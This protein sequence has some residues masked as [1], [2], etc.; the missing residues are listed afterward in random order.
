MRCYKKLLVGALLV[1]CTLHA[2]DNPALLQQGK[3]PIDYVDPF[4]GTSNSRWMQFPG[5]SMPFG[6]VQLSPD[7]QDQGWKGGYDYHINS[8]TGFSHIHSWTM[9]GLLVMPATGELQIEPGTEKQ[10]WKGY[11]SL[12]RKENEVSR[13][14]Y[15]SVFLDDYK[16]KAELTST[17]RVGVHRY[18]FP[19]NYRSRILF[20]LLIDA[21]YGYELN[22][23]FVT[24]V[25]DTEI[26]GFTFQQGHGG[27]SFNEYMVNFYIRFSKPFVTFNGWRKDEICRNIDGTFTSGWGHKDAGFFVEYDTEEGEQIQVQVGL[28]L[29]SPEQARLNLETEMKPFGWDFEAVVKNQENTWN[30]LLGKVEVESDNEINIKKFYTNMYR[31]YLARTIWSDV[32]GKYMDMY[33]KVQQ[34]KDP[35]SVVIGCDAFWNS[36]W[37][38]NGLWNLVTPAWSEKH[39]NSLLEI[40]DKGGWLPKGPAGIEYSGI[41]VGS[42]SIELIVS[43]YQAGIRNFDTMKA[44]EAMIH[45]QTV[46]G[47][48]HDAGGYAG[49]RNLDVYMKYGY[50]PNEFGPVTNTLDYA[51]DDWAVSEFA[52][53]LGD[54]EQGEYFAKRS[55]NFENVFDPSVK[56]VHMKNADGSWVEPFDS[57]CCSTFLGSGYVEGNAWQ[58]TWFV[59]HDVRYVV[60]FLGREEF[61]ARLNRGFKVSEPW[62]FSSESVDWS[63]SLESMGRLPINHGN[64]PNMQAAYL[65]NYAGRPWLTQ[66]WVRSIMERFYGDKPENGWMGDEDEGQM[67]AWYTLSSLGLFQMQG[68]CAQEPVWDIGSPQFKRA[69]IHLDDTY[70]SGKQFVIET[71]NGSD[72]NIYIQ[73]AYLNGK[74]HNKPWIYHK[75]IVKGG[76]LK[77]V[78]GPEPNVDWG[79]MDDGIEPDSVFCDL[80]MPPLGEGV[81]GADGSISIDLKDGR[82][83]FMWGDSFLGDVTDDKRSPDSKLVIGNVFTVLDSVG[84]ISTLYNGDEKTP[85]SYIAADPVENFPTWYWPGH[86]FVQNGI[87]HLF[88]SKF[89]KKSADMFGFVYDCCDY[90]RLDVKTMKV[91]DKTS[92]GAA[93]INGVHYGHAVLPC[94]DGVYIYGTLVNSHGGADVHVAK[95]TLA[96]G[97]LGDF[98]YWDGVSWQADAKKSAK[99]EGITQSVS[100]Q[101]NVVHL[102]GKIALITQDRLKNVK[103]IYSFTASRPQ[104]P[105][106]NEKLIYTVDEDNYEA[107]SMMTYNA[108]VHPQ[109]IRKDKV[110]MCYNVNTYSAAKLFEKAS[111]YRP[112]F[113][114]VPVKKITE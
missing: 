11:R 53:T 86:G 60:D 23:A 40:Y 21:E 108:M 41:M 59:P 35:D 101:F 104:G 49:N 87:L 19:K 55:R 98:V 34:L 12:Y 37:N 6:M 13:V 74:K 32:N 20:D 3:R 22:N 105:F 33:E 24:K 5:P 76:H 56:Y 43:A 82:N 81:T 38:L 62:N 4:I 9:A 84:H 29:V 17:T 46:Q 25:S 90:F 14:G 107:D 10:P 71:V 106:G 79:S 97:K 69:V 61:S 93:T 73:S 68:G 67:G 109:Y 52:K 103:D 70:Y 39:V 94:A 99:L 26:Q 66:K 57:L 58:Y 102:D 48:A 54:K 16:V 31:S 80:L 64:Q 114:W 44:L 18:T 96:D 75:E 36:F 78:M 89:Y 63:E 65:F 88:M 112:R 30:A 113:L 2:K 45:Q 95:A 47:R 111:L 1:S 27:A 92:F 7:N 28:S 15:Y 8:I 42:H 85:S 91:L 110:L 72:K 77:F 83:L 51:Y 50:V 100:E